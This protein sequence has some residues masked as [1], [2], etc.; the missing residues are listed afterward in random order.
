MLA[1]I[2]HTDIAQWSTALA[3]AIGIIAAGLATAIPPVIQAWQKAWDRMSETQ[4]GQLEATKQALEQAVQAQQEANQEMARR[5]DRHR[6][7]L[8]SREA[9]IREIGLQNDEQLKR[10]EEQSVLIVDLTTRVTHLAKSIDGI[11]PNADPEKPCPNLACP[12]LLAK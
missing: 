6:K 7:E 4:R 12:K 2:T 10:L 5:E 3:T 11:C 8:E 9:R 1:A